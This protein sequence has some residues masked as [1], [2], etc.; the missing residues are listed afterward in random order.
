MS[1]GAQHTSHPPFSQTDESSGRGGSQLP[2]T[3]E[4]N[5]S[6][7]SQGSQVMPPPAGPVAVPLPAG[8]MRQSSIN[9]LLNDPATTTT[10]TT[11]TGSAAVPQ[12]AQQPAQRILL[13]EDSLRKFH[14]ELVKG[15]SGLSV[16][17]LEQVFSSMMDAIWQ[18]RG[19]W[20]RNAVLKRVLDGFNVTVADIEEVQAVLGPSQ[21]DG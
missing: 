15:S 10:A 20:N 9:N 3:Q 14:G 16:E 13:D 6:S 12:Q 19:E 1:N 18:G 5:F 21:E 2:D 11:G 4:Q 17:Q 7:Q 8:N